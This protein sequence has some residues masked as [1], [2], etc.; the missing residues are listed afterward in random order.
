MSTTSGIT[1]MYGLSGSGM[2]VD[3]MV[4]QLMQAAKQPYNQL[5]QKQQVDE[6][7]KTAYNDVYTQVNSFLDNTVTN[8]ELQSTLTAKSVTST[9]TSVATITANGAAASVNHTLSIS[10][11]ATGITETSSSALTVT[12]GSKT[13]LQS[14]LGLTSPV[15]F[16]I[17][18]ASI[19]ASPTESINDLASAINKATVSTSTN[20]VVSQTS[21][22]VAATYD[23]NTDRFFLYSSTTGSSA[24]IDFTGTN[25]AGLNF[26]S[27][28]LKLNVYQGV[29]SAGVTGTL[30]NAAGATLD[31]KQAL[32]TQLTDWSGPSSFNLKFSDG[33]STANY[34]FDTTRSLN[35]N[36]TALNSALTSAFNPNGTFKNADG[37]SSFTYASYDPATGKLAIKAPSGTNLDLS[38]SDAAAMSYLNNELKLTL[39]AAKTGQDAAFQLDGVTMTQSTNKFTIAGIGYT[40]QSIGST[41]LTVATDID[42]IV[43]N[44]KSFVDTYNSLLSSLYGKINEKYDRDYPPLTDDQKSAMKDTDISLWTDKAKTGL[45]HSDSTLKN[46]VETMRDAFSSAISGV[47]GNYKSAMSLGIA[48]SDDW[49]LNGQLSVNEDTLRSALQA[50]PN[51]VYN[52]FGT[53]GGSDGANGIA[54][55]LSTALNTSASAI[56]DEAGTTSAW[57]SDYKSNLGIEINDYEDKLSD[58]QDKLN[59]QENEYYTRFN[60]MESA[61]SQLSQEQSY[62]S[63][64]LTSS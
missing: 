16:M 20:G 52:V 39:G 15:S 23:T 34:A 26:L 3:S 46:L 57:D 41:N 48:E 18:G 47:T 32:N 8:F 4:K 37:T 17:N 12:Y 1:R 40:L 63:S 7:K 27:Q 35:D 22:G 62:V 11:L 25:T 54:L 2:D 58:M 51:A 53:S 42:K 24:K 21:I 5:W 36:L 56:V 49:T 14:Q 10:Q 44:V 9:D 50:D 43:S 60:A 64:L 61:Y 38:G 33:T 29:G 13:T 55:R 19:T 30:T 28:Q 6:W 59:T 31:A 45:L